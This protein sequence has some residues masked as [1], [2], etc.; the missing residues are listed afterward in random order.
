MYWPHATCC[1]A[2]EAESDDTDQQILFGNVVVPIQASVLGL[3]ADQ[4]RPDYVGCLFTKEE[5]AFETNGPSLHMV[6]VPVILPLV[7]H[8]P[9]VEGEITDARVQAALRRY[10]KM[11]F[12]FL[13]AGIWLRA[14]PY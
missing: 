7:P 2:N 10:G 11:A 4:K 5:A 9:L 13:E 14:C 1:I 6:Q 12:I 8:H 3:A